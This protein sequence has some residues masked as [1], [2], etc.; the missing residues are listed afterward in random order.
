MQGLFSGCQ[1]LLPPSP[2]NSLV[3]FNSTWCFRSQ[4]KQT[5]LREDL[6]SPHPHPLSPLPPTP[7]SSL[8]FAFQR[9]PVLSSKALISVCNYTFISIV[10]CPPLPPAS[11]SAPGVRKVFFVH[12][13]VLKPNIV[14]GSG[15]AC[16]TFFFFFFA[17]VE[18]VKGWPKLGFP[19]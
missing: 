1:R 6:L 10:S 18:W 15:D 17:V 16:N 8:F 2:P 12:R 19:S 3:S 13:L 7:P 14:P 9:A 4:L 11:L 5:F